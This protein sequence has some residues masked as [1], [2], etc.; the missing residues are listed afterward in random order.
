MALTDLPGAINVMRWP[1]HRPESFPYAIAS[2]TSLSAVSHKYCISGPFVHPAGV[3]ASKT[4]TKIHFLAG[5]ITDAGTAGDTTIRI[6]LQGV[7]TGA[8][9]PRRADGT[10]LSGGNAYA[11]SAINTF[12]SDAWSTS[13]TIN[14]G[15][16]T[17]VTVGTDISAVWEITVFGTGDSFIIKGLTQNNLAGAIDRMHHGGIRRATSGTSYST[18]TV[19]GN[20]IFE[21]DDGSFG[22]LGNVDPNAGVGSNAFANNVQYGGIINLPVPVRVRGIGALLTVAASASGKLALY[23]NPLTGT[24]T[25]LGSYTFDVARIRVA[26]QALYT[27][28]AFTSS[29]DLAAN[30]NY[31]VAVI[32]THATNQCA[33][34]HKEMNVVG[35][36]DVCAGQNF[37]LV[38]SPD[39]TSNFSNVNSGKNVPLVWLLIE[40]LDD[41]AGSGGGGPLI[42][43]RLVLA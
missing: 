7:A 9:A 8:T 17:A 11:D 36:L 37:R 12:T 29:V 10:Y 30:T 43:G 35:H 28:E 25:E 15:S 4:I 21:C 32:S 41:G 39:A 20:V 3:G 24:L 42:G 16:G 19:T 31:C 2:P 38:T 18:T 13:G 33:V 14:G 6:G 5:T 27:E 23:S 34:Y 22:T 26:S 1:W 40:S